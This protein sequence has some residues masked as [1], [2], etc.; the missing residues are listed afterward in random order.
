MASVV[1]GRNEEVSIR[2]AMETGLEHHRAGRLSQAE[3][4]YRK[5]LQVTPNH[6]DALS[7][8]G[9]IAHQAGK[10]ELAVELIGKAISANPGV[11]NYHNQLGIV[12]LDQGKPDE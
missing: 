5:I 11:A 8:L 2:D 12:L 4:I 7:L 1:S 9:A 3:A 6:S 10:R